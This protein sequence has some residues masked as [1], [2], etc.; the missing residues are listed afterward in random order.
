MAIRIQKLNVKNLGP[1][2][3][4]S[5]QFRLVNLIYGHNEQGKTYLVEFIYRSL[6]KNMRY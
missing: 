6:F 2:H 3:E 1:I 5:H 4:F